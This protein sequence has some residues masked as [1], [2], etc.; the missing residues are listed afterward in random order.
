MKKNDIQKLYY[1]IKKWNPNNY[2][3]HNIMT[4]REGR[5]VHWVGSLYK[6]KSINSNEIDIKYSLN[7]SNKQIVC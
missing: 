5:R 7:M 4:L 3:H 2:Y 6:V 1:K